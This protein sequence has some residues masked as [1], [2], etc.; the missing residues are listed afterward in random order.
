MAL[1]KED[2]LKS[3]TLPPTLMSIPEALL[4]PWHRGESAITLM[5][6]A[7]C[8]ALDGG[9]S[10][11]GDSISMQAVSMTAN[12]FELRPREKSI[13]NVLSSALLV[14]LLASANPGLADLAKCFSMEILLSLTVM[15]DMRKLG[16][17][18]L[19]LLL[20]AVSLEAVSCSWVDLLPPPVIGVDDLCARV[21]ERGA[22]T[23]GGDLR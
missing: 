22:A 13:P 2:S 8:R 17:T 1:R 12:A 5:E 9:P 14:M 10:A 16:S 19:R 4:D 15:G 18:G 3:D 21:L 23:R 7:L 11:T 20:E 6:L